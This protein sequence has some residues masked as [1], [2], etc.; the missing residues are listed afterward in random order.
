VKLEDS[1]MSLFFFCF[2]SR[3]THNFL[4]IKAELFELANERTNETGN[5]DEPSARMEPRQG[6]DIVGL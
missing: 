4:P 5:H 1:I 2:A 6:E 3:V